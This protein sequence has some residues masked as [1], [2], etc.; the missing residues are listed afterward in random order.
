MKKIV[1]KYLTWTYNSSLYKGLQELKKEYDLDGTSLTDVIALMKDI[2]KELPEG[3]N[4]ARL[5]VEDDDSDPY[6]DRVYTKTYVKYDIL[7][8]DEE[9]A[10]RKAAVKK[11]KADRQ[12][13]LEAD[14]ERLKKELGK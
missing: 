9:E 12:A 14:F 6:S 11:E 1:T 3:A 13:R 5:S 7:E 4:N 10:D 2:Q 8:T